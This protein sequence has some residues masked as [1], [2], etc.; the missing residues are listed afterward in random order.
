VYPRRA[1]NA[2]PVEEPTA[3]SVC[4][5]RYCLTHRMAREDGHP[6]PVLGCELFAR[7][8]GLRW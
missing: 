1:A 2:S 4:G 7:A 5:R 8:E 6:E 3:L